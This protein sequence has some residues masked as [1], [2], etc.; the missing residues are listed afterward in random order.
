MISKMTIGSSNPTHF[1]FTTYTTT[2]WKVSSKLTISAI[3]GPGLSSL[4]IV[5]NREE[6]QW[7]VANKQ[8]YC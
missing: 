4:A 2:I 8:N 5:E 3:P 7:N 6:N 1:S